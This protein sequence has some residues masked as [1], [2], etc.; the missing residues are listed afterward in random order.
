MLSL[1]SL[2]HINVYKDEKTLV[3]KRL[4]FQ[5]FLCQVLEPGWDCWDGMVGERRQSLSSQ[6]AAGGGRLL[7][8]RTATYRGGGK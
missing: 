7:E 8:P 4:M 5:I 2:P 6:S 3:I 1:S